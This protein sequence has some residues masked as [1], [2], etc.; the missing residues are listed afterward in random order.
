M[1]KKRFG[2]LLKLL[3]TSHRPAERCHFPVTLAPEQ[4]HIDMSQW[5]MKPNEGAPGLPT[6]GEYHNQQEVDMTSQGQVQPEGSPQPNN[7]DCHNQAGGP[8]PMDYYGQNSMAPQQ[9][10]H[11]ISIRIR[12]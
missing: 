10:E 6:D 4:Q 11:S 1:D 7:R 8:S 2:H 3:H 9:Q 12:G 5:Q